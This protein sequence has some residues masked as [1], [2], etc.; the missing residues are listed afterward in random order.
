MCER[1]T[2]GH[3]VRVHGRR[4]DPDE[5]RWL[6]AERDLSISAFAARSGI[7]RRH[8]H[9]I[10]AREKVP[11]ERMVLRLSQAM[12]VPVDD[13]TVAGDPAAADGEAA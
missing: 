11:T 12:G 13:F 6:I 8:V 10:L 9:A 3:S 2:L 7:S 4:I 1:G 5:L